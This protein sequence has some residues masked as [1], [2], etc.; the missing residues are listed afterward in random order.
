[1]ASCAGPGFLSSD[2]YDNQIVPAEGIA[3]LPLATIFPTQQYMTQLVSFASPHVSED[4]IAAA[5]VSTNKSVTKT[6]RK[7]RE[8]R[9]L[10]AEVDARLQPA[11]AELCMHVSFTECAFDMVFKN[12]IL[13]LN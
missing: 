2:T 8:A 1:M 4:D 11:I 10:I 7:K 13:L 9:R 3:S 5:K 12:D 6:V